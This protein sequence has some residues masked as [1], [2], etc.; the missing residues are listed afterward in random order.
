MATI[1]T[2]DLRIKNASNFINSLN[3]EERANAY[4]FLGRVQPWA[5]D[6]APPPPQN[7]FQEFYTTYDNMVALNRVQVNDVYHMI[8]KLKW[9]SGVAYDRYQ[10]NYTI[11]NR[12]LTGASN[13]YDARFYVITST[14]TV[15][16]CLDNNNNVV[17]TVEP[18]GTTTEPFYTSDGYQWL[19]LFNINN[20]ILL[21]RSTNNL[22]PVKPA[23]GTVNTQ[24]DGAIYT[25]LIDDPGLLYTVNPTGA[26]NNISFYYAHIEGDGNGAV[27][28]VYIDNTAISKIEVARSGGSYTFAT[29]NFTAG[30]VYQSLADLDLG[31]NGLDPAGNGELRTTVIISPPGG[32]GS[33]LNRE[34]G[35]T[36]VGVFTNLNTPLLVQ[37]YNCPFRQIGLLQDFEYQGINPTSLNACFAVLV[38]GVRGGEQFIIGETIEQ[39]I[40]FEGEIKRAK[41]TVVAY[42]PDEDVLRYVQSAENAD[43]DGSVYP[44]GGT[45]VI[46]GL[47]SKLSGTPFITSATVTDMTFV[48]GY[49]DPDLTKYSGYMTYLSNISPITRDPLQSERV[50]LVV[51]F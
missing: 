17:S 10:H 13:L 27:A 28:K 25:V 44:F 32:W 35:G 39:K 15:Y 20:D 1:N 45:N 26:T 34:L 37:S 2:N 48:D 21:S 43:T 18:Q 19:R 47:T 11:V 36:R 14:N 7:N 31:V 5:D 49:A 16:V 33:D 23:E 38:T 46:E 22:M 42:D 24:L 3:D 12:S 41:G 30:N 50:S 51:A 29:L 4:L 8:T 9:V 40:T 6:N